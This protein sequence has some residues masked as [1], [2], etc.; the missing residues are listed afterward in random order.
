MTTRKQI[1]DFLGQKRLAVVGV[2]RSPKDFT[3]ALFRELRLRGYDLVPVNP[4]VP[5]VEGIRCYDRVQDVSPPVESAL[6]LTKP[7]VTDQVVR[8]CAQAGVRRI[9]MFR[10]AG[11]GA[12][13]HGAAALCEAKGVSMIAGECP[14]M[15][16]PGAALFHRVHGFCRKLFGTYP[17]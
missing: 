1:D 6:L 9:W 16:L 7:P 14:F 3:R 15:F 2:S 8:E 13:S 11:P 17:R 10:A 5:E 12:V 4:G